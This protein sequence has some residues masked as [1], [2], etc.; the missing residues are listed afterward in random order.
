MAIKNLR[1][2]DASN[3]INLPQ[4]PSIT[5]V[6]L[7][8][9]LIILITIH[10]SAVVDKVVFRF[11]S[12][13]SYSRGSVKFKK[14]LPFESPEHFEVIRIL[15]VPKALLSRWKA[16]PYYYCRRFLHFRWLGEKESSCIKNYRG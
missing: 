16:F 10:L 11:A 7:P 5:I 9:E 8:P 4:E 14:D 15:T 1:K 6:D 13:R 3:I 2:K 12:W